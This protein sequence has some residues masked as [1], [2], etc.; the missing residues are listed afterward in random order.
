MNPLRP[1]GPSSTRGLQRAELRTM[2]PAATEPGGMVMVDFL[3][4]LAFAGMVLSP[5]FIASFNM[6]KM[7]DEQM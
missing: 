4:G 1:A 5:A 7:D 2:Q 6:A 3:L